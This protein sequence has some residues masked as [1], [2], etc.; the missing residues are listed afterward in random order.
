MDG[1]DGVI[2]YHRKLQALE[3][4]LCEEIYEIHRRDAGDPERL[5]ELKELVQLDHAECEQYPHDVYKAKM[6]RKFR[7]RKL[8]LLKGLSRDSSL[9]P[10]GFG[11]VRGA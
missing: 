3:C 4:T 5:E 10:T 11:T 2:L 9:Q 8:K 1:G 6:A 7:K